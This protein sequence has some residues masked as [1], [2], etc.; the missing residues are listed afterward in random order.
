[1][2]SGMS[3]KVSIQEYIEFYNDYRPHSA[4]GHL[5]PNEAEELYLSR[6]KAS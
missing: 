6:T 4:I 3:G 5:S 1:M 2:I